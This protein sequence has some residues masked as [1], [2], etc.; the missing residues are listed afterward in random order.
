MGEILPDPA[1]A[2]VVGLIAYGNRLRLL[3]DSED[4]GWTGKLWS[5]LRGKA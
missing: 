4:K 3:R 5:V 1:F 2:T